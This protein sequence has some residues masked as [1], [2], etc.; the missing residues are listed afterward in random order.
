MP[1]HFSKVNRGSPLLTLVL[2]LP[3]LAEASAA[4][5]AARVAVLADACIPLKQD[6]YH[7]DYDP[8]AS[9]SYDEYIRSRA[10]RHP[11]GS[12]ARKEPPL[13]TFDLTGDGN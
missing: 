3:S 12:R 2:L 8:L 9:G 13:P 5:A 4:G 6:D 11:W 7:R 10:Q 1:E